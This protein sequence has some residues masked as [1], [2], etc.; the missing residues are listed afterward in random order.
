MKKIIFIIIAC[1]S[2]NIIHAKR[3]SYDSSRN[4]RQKNKRMTQQRDNLYHQIAPTWFN[5]QLRAQYLQL[6]QEASLQEQ[7]DWLREQLHAKQEASNKRDALYA[8]YV[9]TMTES[10]RYNYQQRPTLREQIDWLQKYDCTCKGLQ[11]GLQEVD[12]D[13]ED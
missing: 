12:D 9:D 7:I 11:G 4:M 5:A 8:Q 10:Q 2:M 13:D 3:A 6:T 1:T